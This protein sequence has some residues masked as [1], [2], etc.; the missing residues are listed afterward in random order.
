MNSKVSGD[1]TSSTLVD[2]QS[3]SSENLAVE[4]IF[5]FAGPIPAPELLKQYEEVQSGTA[6]WI[7]KASDE[8][9]AHR[10]S[11]EKL[12]ADKH[13]GGIKRS[14]FLLTGI[15]LAGLGVL[16]FAIYAGSAWPV[17]LAF[18]AIGSISVYALASNL[19]QKSRSEDRQE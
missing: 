7:L 17:A 16:A 12:Y 15:V 6:N 10:H 19:E 4:Q 11:L 9:R 18:S 5:R 3:E 8:E 2:N 13:L 14:Q 1:N